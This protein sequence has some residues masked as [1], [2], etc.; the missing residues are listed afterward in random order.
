MAE[1]NLKDDLKIEQLAD[2]RER[3]ELVSQLLWDQLKSHLQTLRP[4]LA[5][6]R[7]LGNYVRSSIKEDIPDADVALKRPRR[8]NRRPH[9]GSDLPKLVLVTKTNLR[10]WL[11]TLPIS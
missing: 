5:P 1:K 9:A 8:Q 11:G 2:L 7:I 4:L 3:T 6:R 10:P